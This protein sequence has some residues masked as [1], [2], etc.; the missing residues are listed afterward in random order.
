MKAAVFT[1]LNKLEL[2]NV[3]TPEVD[4]NSALLKVRACAIC[5][6]DLRIF[7]HGNT[8]VDPPQTLGHESAGEIVAVGENVTRVKVG[9][10]I[11][12]GADVPCGECAF[13][14]DGMGT[15]CQINYAMGYQFAGS[16]AEY[17]LL[18][19]KV[20]DYGPIHHI[21]EGMSYAEAALAEPLAC[22][23]NALERTPIKLLDTVVIVG[24]GPI[25]CM[26]I[27]IAKMMGASKVIVV[28]RSRGSRAEIASQ[29]GADLVIISSEEDAVERVREET[30]GLGAH[31]VITA[32]PTPAS[33]AEALEMARNRG[34]INLFGGLP[35]GS[36]VELDTNLIHYKELLVSGAHGSLPTHHRKA[37]EL[38]ASGAVPV[39]ELISHRFGL[40]DIHKA[41]DAAENRH[42]LRVLVEPW[43]PSDA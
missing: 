5:G 26:F 29:F 33:H 36:T 21:P 41:F 8:R 17:V 30:D 11:S 2:K 27:P 1:E 34:R 35:A 6:S 43:G 4:P 14:E 24:A 23:L 37:L 31:V 39:S 42:G 15:N 25:G 3:E 16:F 28:Q 10:R 22:V 19:K 20:I 40:S 18:N 7:R 9:D 32:N 38:I 13:C 12:L